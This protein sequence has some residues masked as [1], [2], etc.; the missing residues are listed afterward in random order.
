MTLILL[1]VSLVM[2]WLPPLSSAAA[3]A[4]FP[5]QIKLR[6]GVLHAPPFAYLEPAT[7][8]DGVEPSFQGFQID[9]L[10]LLKLYA[11]K[12]NVT[13]DVDLSLAPPQYDIAFHHV[14]GENITHG[15]VFPSR[16]DNRE[17]LFGCGIHP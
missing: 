14:A 1:L 5:S 10:E 8:D 11:E 6:G 4:N 7:D 16:A 12:D 15:A 9:L 3:S 17:V 13:L 2:W